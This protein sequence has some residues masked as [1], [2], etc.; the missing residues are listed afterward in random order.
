MPKALSPPAKLT[1]IFLF[2][3]ALDDGTG[4]Y[5]TVETLMEMTGL[6]RSA[7]FRAIKEMIDA[8]YLVDDGWKLYRNG[9]KVRRRRLDLD[10]MARD[11]AAEDAIHS[12]THG[13]VQSPTHGTVDAA[14]QSHLRDTQSPT[15]GTGTVP[16]MGLKPSLEPPHKPARSACARV[17]EGSDQGDDCAGA[18]DAVFGIQPAVSP[19]PA[20]Q[21]VRDTPQQPPPPGWKVPYNP[22]PRHINYPPIPPEP[23]GDP[24]RWMPRLSDPEHRWSVLAPGEEIDPRSMT[25]ARRQA[26]GAW[27]LRD[28][29][30]RVADVLGWTADPRRYIDWRPLCAWLD[31][32][33]DPLEVIL[34]TIR[35][36]VE[37]RGNLEISTLAY[38]DR[39]VREAAAAGRRRR[40]G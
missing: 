33:I 14:A 22:T 12:P 23:A 15:H 6:S 37:R 10:L 18:F 5:C 21:P 7:Q 34:P 20:P 19:A 17:R 11:R 39:A 8:A 4:I 26:R 24:L 28:L 2:T 31:D 25:G 9:A 1:A 13:T 30:E 16:P 38:F 36:V 40:A 27:I 29:A 3:H 35:R 32:G